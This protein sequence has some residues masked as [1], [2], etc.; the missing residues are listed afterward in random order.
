MFATDSFNYL[1][2]KLVVSSSLLITE[3]IHI[4]VVFNS[5]PRI[6]FKVSF[7]FILTRVV[8]SP[9]IEHSYG[10]VRMPKAIF[11]SHLQMIVLLSALSNSYTICLLVT[12]LFQCF[13]YPND[14]G[15]SI[16][17]TYY[18]LPNK[19]LLFYHVGFVMV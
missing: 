5:V 3:S 8:F 10:Y 2:L 4:M 11:L 16:W 19:N 18:C 1:C 13:D 9:F 15:S 14:F 17:I 12:C 7:N 6:I